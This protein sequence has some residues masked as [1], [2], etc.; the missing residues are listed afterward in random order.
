MKRIST[1]AALELLA[2]FSFLGLAVG[3][4][5]ISMGLHT[6]N[7]ALAV[8]FF[9]MFVNASYGLIRRFWAKNA[10]KNDADVR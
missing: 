5:R 1:A 9:L 3:Y 10:P 4:A 6:P 8:C 2:V 7:W